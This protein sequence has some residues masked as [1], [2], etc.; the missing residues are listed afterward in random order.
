MIW[1]RH[2]RQSCVATATI[3]YLASIPW[4]TSPDGDSVF[5]PVFQWIWL[6]LCTSMCFVGGLLQLEKFAIQWIWRWRWCRVRWGW[7]VRQVGRWRQVSAGDS[8]PNPPPSSW[9]WFLL[10]LHL[11]T[12][13]ACFNLLQYG[14]DRIW[15]QA[16]PSLLVSPVSPD[17]NGGME[18]FNAFQCWGEKPQLDASDW[19]PPESSSRATSWNFGT[20][21]FNMFWWIWS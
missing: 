20:E 3:R 9:S 4:R 17:L 19:Q 15:M 8:T 16:I 10:R 13:M 21:W 7:I 18:C 12:R 11:M 2:M 5:C 14:C 1:S 6:F